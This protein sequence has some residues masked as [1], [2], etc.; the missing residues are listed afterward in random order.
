MFRVAADR[1]GEQ[2]SASA[3]FGIVLLAGHGVLVL[4]VVSLFVGFSSLELAAFLQAAM[5]PVLLA[6][7][8]TTVSGR[9]RLVSV[10][11]VAP[12]FGAATVAGAARALVFGPRDAVVTAAV[13]VLLGAGFVASWAVL[14]FVVGTAR[15]WLRRRDR[16]GRR[17]LLYSAT[18]V[19]LGGAASFVSYALFWTYFVVGVGDPLG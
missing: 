3:V 4:G 19:F 11:A 5:V 13:V 9:P 17:E 15:R 6:A 1:V 2:V 14:G 12:L 18:A 8:W 16:I 10:V 7:A